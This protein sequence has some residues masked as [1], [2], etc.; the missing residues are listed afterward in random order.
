MKFSLDLKELN[1][2]LAVVTKA[3]SPNV[4]TPILKGIYL[5]AYGNELYLKCSD[6]S[7][8]IETLIPAMIEEEGAAVL[9]GRLTADLLRKMRGN[10]VNFETEDNSTVKV[11]TGKSRSSLSFFPADTYPQMDELSGDVTFKIK[12]GVFRSM[13]KQTAFCCAGDDEGK[14]ILRGVLMEFTEEGDLNFVALDG[15]RLAKRTESIKVSGSKRNAV[16]PARTMQDIANIISDSDDELTVT[17]ST[18][19]ITVNM[20]TTKIKARLLKGE[21]INYRNILSK[22]I[23]SRVVVNRAELQE[24]LEIASLFSKETQN[25]LIKLDFESDKLLITARSET[26]SINESTDI[27]LTGSPIEIAFNARYLLEIIKAIDDETVAL[28]FNTSVTPC[29]AE[30]VQGN[31]YYYLVL[32]VRIMKS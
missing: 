11:E 1:E 19:H 21:Y 25:N 30:P 17:L 8:Q 9:P 3:L 23:T 32:P 16:V 27:T 7:V 29:V 2:A 18:T 26:G 24:S 6:S 13:I 20:G 12:Q 28:S 4:D 5:S 31:K 10:S 14:A 22:K 15:F